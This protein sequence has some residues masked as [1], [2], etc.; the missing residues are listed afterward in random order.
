MM[1]ESQAQAVRRG[2]GRYLDMV[3]ESQAQ[4]VRREGGGGDEASGPGMV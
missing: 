3:A 2:G 1:A 4:A